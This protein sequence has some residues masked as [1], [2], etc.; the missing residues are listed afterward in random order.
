MPTRF[1]TSSY[2][3]ILGVPSLTWA[4]FAPHQIRRFK[5]LSTTRRGK[6]RVKSRSCAVRKR[7]IM[8]K[9]WLSSSA[10]PTWR[11]METFSWPSPNLKETANFRSFIS[12]SQSQRAAMITGI[13]FSLI[14]TP[15][16]TQTMTKIFFS[17]FSSSMDLVQEDIRKLGKQPFQLDS[18]LTVETSSLK[19]LVK[20]ILWL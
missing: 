5:S 20:A 9:T 14:Q 4:N 15:C 13:R 11:K 17:R 3:S 10:L 7:T 2:R 19:T 6:T 18:W 12:L 1:R 16:M 8:V